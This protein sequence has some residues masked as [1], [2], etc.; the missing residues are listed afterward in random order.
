MTSMHNNPNPDHSSP[1]FPSLPPFLQFAPKIAIMSS[2]TFSYA[3]IL[4]S[5]TLK[6]SSLA[7]A[8]CGREPPLHHTQ[9]A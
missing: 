5:Y 1:P 9:H 8:E 2:T 6:S 4:P 7:R 3:L